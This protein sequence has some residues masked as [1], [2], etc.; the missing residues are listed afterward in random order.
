M[1]KINYVLLIAFAGL[2]VSCI[3]NQSPNSAKNG[4]TKSQEKTVPAGWFQEDVAPYLAKDKSEQNLISQFNTYKKALLI[5]DVDNISR[6]M[7]R[8]AIKYYK[9]YYPELSEDE[10]L[11]GFLKE[12]ANIY[13]KAKE[14]YNKAGIDYDII[15]NDMTKKVSEKESLIIIFTVTGIL[16][17]NEKKLH[18]A[19]E[20]TVGISNNGGKNWNFMAF[21]DEIPNILRMRFSEETI[22]GIMNY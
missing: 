21:T 8:E 2:L 5:G 19:P 9:K 13:A 20:A 22:N 16:S 1:R 4:K 6:Y 18:S 10:I 3:S 12:T 11:K 17:K 15:I 14:E 7:Y